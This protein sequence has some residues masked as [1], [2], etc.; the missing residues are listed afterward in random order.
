MFLTSTHICPNKK[1]LLHNLKL[2]KEKKPKIT[3]HN[4]VKPHEPQFHLRG[5]PELRGRK[6]K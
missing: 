3:H 4:S 2:K 1:Y 6:E 5:S